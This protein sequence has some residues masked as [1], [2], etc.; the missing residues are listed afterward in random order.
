MLLNLLFSPFD[1]LISCFYYTCKWWSKRS[2]PKYGVAGKPT[3]TPGYHARACHNDGL[4]C[5]GGVKI[6]EIHGDLPLC[7]ALLI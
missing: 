7:Q 5:G 6:G 4:G 3:S 1:L 2:S